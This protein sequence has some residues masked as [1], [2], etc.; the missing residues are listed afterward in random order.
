MIHVENTLKF[1]KYTVKSVINIWIKINFWNFWKKLENIFKDLQFLA[2][3]HCLTHACWVSS[4]ATLCNSL[5]CNS[6]GPS[7]HGILQ[8][9]MLEC[10]AISS[11]RGFSQLM[12]WTQDSWG[13]WKTF[14]KRFIVLLNSKFSWNKVFAKYSIVLNRSVVSNSLQPFGL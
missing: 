13:S 11:S 3:A 10:V 2:S 5:H 8:A 6:P 14:L 1:W 12:D 9:R 7:V 4:V